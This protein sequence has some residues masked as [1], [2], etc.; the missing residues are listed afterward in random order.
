MVKLNCNFVTGLAPMWIMTFSSQKPSHRMKT[1]DNRIK[2]ENNTEAV[3][4]CLR[5]AWID[6]FL[7]ALF[8]QNH[9]KR[10]SSKPRISLSKWKRSR[11]LSITKLIQFN[12]ILQ[13]SLNLNLKQPRTGGL[14]VYSSPIMEWF[15][16]N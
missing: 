1:K 7:L 16:I 11:F 2:R 5:N 9:D 14:D 8:A 13:H 12:Y 15:I 6:G 10:I 3:F 4:G